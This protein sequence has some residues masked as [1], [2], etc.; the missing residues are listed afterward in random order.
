MTSEEHEGPRLPIGLE[1]NHVLVLTGPTAIG[2]KQVGFELARRIGAEIVGLDSIKVYR[3]L[4]IGSAQPDASERRDV[5]V[6][7]VGIATPEEPFSVGRYIE[8]AKQ[9]VA[10]IRSRSRVPLFL[11]GTPL[12]LNAILRGFFDG[13]P[14]DPEIRAR[15]EERARAFGVE[16]VHADLAKVDKESAAWI[17][18]RDLKRIERALEVFEI[19]G[20]PISALQREG[21]VLPIAGTIRVF[22]LTAADD[23]LRERQRQRVDRMI[24]EGLVSEVAELDRSGALKGEAARAIGYRE[25]LAHLRGEWS[26]DV[27]IQEIIRN[28][29]DL[30]RK[31]RKWLRRFH[32][33]AWIDR[34]RDDST[35]MLVARILEC[36]AIGAT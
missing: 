15:I 1:A 14:A 16:S 27:A 17:G 34:S 12:Y 31:Q 11:G 2:K 22:G 3:G 10:E 35:E 28:N 21:T 25:I 32:E 30:T 7:L 13:P 8:L 26:L 20:R 24:A 5:P 19:T 23:L 9:V 18:V 29:W 33:I 4:A 6:H 36:I